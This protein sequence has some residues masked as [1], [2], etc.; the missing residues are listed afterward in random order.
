MD[1]DT[2][3]SAEKQHVYLENKA[4]FYCIY[5]QRLLLYYL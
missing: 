1:V 5:K 3:S 2:E 4:N